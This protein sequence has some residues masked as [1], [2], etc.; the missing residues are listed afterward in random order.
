MPG[1]I[2]GHARLDRS[3]H[4]FCGGT[5]TDIR[6]TTRYSEADFCSALLGVLHETGHGLY[7][8]NLPADFMRQPVGALR[9]AWR[10]MRASR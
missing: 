4:P 10:C 1:W 5:Q 2:T 8:Q 3:A 6:I 9:P 7:E